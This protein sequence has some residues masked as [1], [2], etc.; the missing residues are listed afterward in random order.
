[1]PMALRPNNFFLMGF[2]VYNENSRI[3]GVG[4]AV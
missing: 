4:G 1:M 3:M 2:G